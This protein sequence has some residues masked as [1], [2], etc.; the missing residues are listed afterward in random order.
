MSVHV[1]GSRILWSV[2]RTSLHSQSQPHTS[3]TS[4]TYA[5]ENETLFGPHVLPGRAHRKS[6]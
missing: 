1:Y 6:R 4:T 2:S 3:S 5:C